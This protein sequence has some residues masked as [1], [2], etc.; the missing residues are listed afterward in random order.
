[1][2]FEFEYQGDE[3]FENYFALPES[4]YNIG[5]PSPLIAADNLEF[6]EINGGRSDHGHCSPSNDPNDQLEYELD[7]DIEDPLLFEDPGSPFLNYLSMNSTL[8]T[9]E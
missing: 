7:R 1:M 6:P 2:N 9:R 3:G 8:V 5:I 4:P